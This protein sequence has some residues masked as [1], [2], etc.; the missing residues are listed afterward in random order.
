[1][2]RSERLVGLLFPFAACMMLW[3][4]FLPLPFIGLFLFKNMVVAIGLGIISVLPLSYAFTSVG[5]FRHVYWLLSNK[6]KGSKT[7]LDLLFWP[8]TE[9]DILGVQRSALII[10]IALGLLYLSFLA[11][12][13]T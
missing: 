10:L 12:F 1:M 5:D 8:I 9:E 3:L 6:P 2:A 7:P 13:P 11:F 4:L